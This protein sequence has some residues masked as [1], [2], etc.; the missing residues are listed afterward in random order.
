MAFIYIIVAVI[1]V[2]LIFY[3]NVVN[4]KS[5]LNQVNPILEKFIE[6]DYEFLLRLK[7]QSDDIDVSQLFQKRIRNAILAVILANFALLITGYFNY[8]FFVITIVLGIFIFK[9]SYIQ[10]KAFYR[11]RLKTIEG[12]LPYYLKGLEIL[13]QHYTVPVGI[14]RSI[15]SAPE[16]FKPGLRKLVARIDAGDSSIQPY[17]D[18]AAEYPVRDSMRMMRLLYRLNLG[19]NQ[20]KHEQI[21]MFSKTVSTLQNKAREQKYKARLEAMERRTMIMLF[22]TGG[23]VILIL[24]LAMTLMMGL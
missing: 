15:E 12:M 22:G 7:Y 17:V 23:G 8:I 4:T 18:F 21:M 9:L 16:I 20:D 19:S 6:S 24:F 2:F 5:F 13:I 14:S 11:T 1:I 10:L 3:N